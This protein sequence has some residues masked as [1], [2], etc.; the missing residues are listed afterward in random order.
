MNTTNAFPYRPHWTAQDIADAVPPRI[1]ELFAASP[2]T[3]EVA[4]RALAPRWNLH[5][6]RPRNEFPAT[7]RVRG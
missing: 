5:R 2:L 3:P 4:K 7:L 6:Y 1:S